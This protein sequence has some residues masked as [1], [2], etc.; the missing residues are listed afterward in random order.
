VFRMDASIIKAA[1]TV[2]N[3]VLGRVFSLTDSPPCGDVGFDLDRIADP[4]LPTTKLFKRN[5][6]AKKKQCA[7]STSRHLHMATTPARMK[8]R[9]NISRKD[10]FPVASGEKKLGP[11]ARKGASDSAADR[12]SASVDHATLFFSI[13]SGLLFFMV[14]LSTSF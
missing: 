6:T 12:A 4:D 1:T 5:S 11:L 3:I 2:I 7:I 14:L 8:S 9:L 13:I 10:G